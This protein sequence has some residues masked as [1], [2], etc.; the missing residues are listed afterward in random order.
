MR[1]RCDRVRLVSDASTI[2][3]GLLFSRPGVA[4]GPCEPQAV[5][6]AV[7]QFERVRF[8]GTDVPDG[9]GFL[10]QYGTYPSIGDGGFRISVVRQLV[11]LD[12]DG[13]FESYT[14]VQCVAS[15]VSDEELRACDRVAWWFRGSSETFDDWLSEV[16]TDPIWRVLAH[17]PDGAWNVSQY[18]V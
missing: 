17:R 16:E 7:K 6:D 9:D 12:Q 1:C 8:D 18:V 4:S 2:L 11:R 3:A 15:H 10:F 5:L 14:Q 13:E